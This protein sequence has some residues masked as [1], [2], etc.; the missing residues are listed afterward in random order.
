MGFYVVVIGLDLYLI[1]AMDRALGRARQA[2]AQ[3]DGLLRQQRAMFQELQHRVANNMQFVSALL[4][5]QRRRVAAE[6]GAAAA[7]LD[8]AAER[9]R[10][11]ARIHRRLHDP[12]AAGV[13]FGEHLR[14]ICWRP[15]GRATSS[16]W[17]RRRRPS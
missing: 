1:Q 8:E 7:A 14:E 17:W 12:A 4:A 2:Q 6:P 13:Q 3:A 11:M 10:S 9:L 15:P 16:A 5:I